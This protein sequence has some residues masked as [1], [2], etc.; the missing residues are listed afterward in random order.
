VNNVCAWGV[1]KFFGAKKFHPGQLRHRFRTPLIRRRERWETVPYETALAAGA[2]LL[3]DARRPVVYG[4]TSVG[5]LAQT[6]ALALARRL[7]AR[8]EPADLHLMAPYYQALTRHEIFWSPLEVIRDEADTVF[9]WG[10][11]PLHSCP[12][13]LARYAVFCRGRFTE[14]GLEDRRVGA[15]DLRKTELAKFCQIFVKVVPGQ[16]LSLLAATAALLQGGGVAAE[17]MKGAGNL[18]D[19]LTRAEYG[20]IFVGRGVSYSPGAGERFLALADLAQTLNRRARFALFPLATDFNSAGL[21]H[22]LLTELGSPLAPD[23]A[24]SGDP[25]W[26]AQPLDFREADA[27]LAAGGDLFWLLPEEQR[28]DLRRRQVPV[29][30][31]SPF[32]NRTTGQA[33]VVLPAALD[34]LETG[35]IAYR[36]DGLPLWLRPVFPALAPPAHQILQ[37]LHDILTTSTFISR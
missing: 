24:G 22:L 13:H 12:R 4:L 29:V 5:V 2:E 34:G 26:D 10:A 16:E 37:D 7:R 14:R 6:A 28:Q 15:A 32:A 1:A 33:A 21:Y 18:A 3:A 27:V 17:G 25:V 35:E 8:L 20:V 30:A 19:F 11:N 9:Y 31:I 23:F 36:M